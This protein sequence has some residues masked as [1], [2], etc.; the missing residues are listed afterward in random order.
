MQALNVD[1][2]ESRVLSSDVSSSVTP[3]CVLDVSIL[4]TYLKAVRTS[5]LQL[6]T[7]SDVLHPGVHAYGAHGDKIQVPF[8]AQFN[9]SKQELTYFSML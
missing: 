6:I 5:F 2:S 8:R 3:C 4:I 1:E 7:D 9:R